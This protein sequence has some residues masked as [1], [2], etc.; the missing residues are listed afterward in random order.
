MGSRATR[1]SPSRS[2]SGRPDRVRPVPASTAPQPRRRALAE[3]EA[4]IAR[5]EEVRARHAG[6]VAAGGPAA[7]KGARRALVL[8]RLGPAAPGGRAPGPA[9]PQPGRP[10]RRRARLARRRPAGGRMDGRKHPPPERAHAGAGPGG[11]PGG[12]RA[13]D[14]RGGRG[15]GGAGGAPS[16]APAAGRGRVAGG[17]R[18]GAAGRDRARAAAARGRPGAAAGGRAGAAP[19]G[20]RPRML[21]RLLRRRPIGTRAGGPASPPCATMHASGRKPARPC[22]RAGRGPMRGGQPHGIHQ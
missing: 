9:A 11:G 22:G 3:V 16:P 15:R 5:A 7:G 18:G 4:H 20:R 17:D 10:G 21:Q 19:G 8:P 1:P 2:S 13:P 14:R 6:D 12:P